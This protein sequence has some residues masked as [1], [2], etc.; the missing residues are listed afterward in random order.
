M[1]SRYSNIRYSCE[2]HA[3]GLRLSVRLSRRFRWCSSTHYY[4]YLFFSDLMKLLKCKKRRWKKCFLFI[5]VFFLSCSQT[6]S[7]SHRH[8]CQQHRPGQ[9][10][11]HGEW[12]TLWLARGT[13]SPAFGCQGCLTI[14][15]PS[16]SPLLSF[17]MRNA[18][19]LQGVVDIQLGKSKFS[20]VKQKT[21]VRMFATPPACTIYA[22]VLFYFAGSQRRHPLSDSG[23]ET[24]GQ[25]TMSFAVCMCTCVS[26]CVCV[27]E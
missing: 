19:W 1:W 27:G 2:T 21:E 18:N 6:D 23:W 10:H 13:L 7:D 17:W 15:W 11:Q 5:S 4:F 22:V 16:S 3:E 24:G 25:A 8:V 14:I 9:R 20:T 12:T 26:V